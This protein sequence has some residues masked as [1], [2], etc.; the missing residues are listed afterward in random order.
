MCEAGERQLHDRIKVRPCR[1]LLLTSPNGIV[2]E[3]MLGSPAL[4]LRVSI[5]AWK[6]H[7]DAAANTNYIVR[8]T[9]SYFHCLNLL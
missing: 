6:L 7:H 1:L 3:P 9:A 4:S 8:H 5:P 2:L